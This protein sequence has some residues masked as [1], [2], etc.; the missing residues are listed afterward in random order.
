M[1][2]VI[3]LPAIHGLDKNK[4]F[5]KGPTRLWNYFSVDNYSLKHSK[6]FKPHLF[7]PT[8]EVKT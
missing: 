3:T 6:I 8:N 5:P 4:C 1:A 2:T 7:I